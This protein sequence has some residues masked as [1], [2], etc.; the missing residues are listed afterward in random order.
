MSL[1]MDLIASIECECDDA[2]EV[3]SCQSCKDAEEFLQMSTRKNSMLRLLIKNAEAQNAEL[4]RLAKIKEDFQ[5]R[6]DMHIKS[7]DQ[8]WHLCH[9]CPCTYEKK[10]GKCESI[11]IE[12]RVNG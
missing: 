8:Y 4:E 9:V 12:P 6:H 3:N 11:W 10:P 1:I 5:N 7:L 2:D